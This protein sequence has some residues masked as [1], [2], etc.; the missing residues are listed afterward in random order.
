MR[1]IKE[2]PLF[3][4]IL[5]V[6]GNPKTLILIEPL[7]GI[8]YNLIAPFIT[9]YMYAFGVTDVQIGLMLSI[10]TAVK[11]IIAFLGGNI[12]DKLGRKTTVVLCDFLGWTL[13]CA[14]WAVSRN[15]WMFL[16]ASLINS[17]EQTNIVAWQCLL[18]EDAEEK[19][20]VTIYT[21][22]TIAGL[23]AAFF[24]P[25]S[26]LLIDRHSLV[27]VIRVLYAVFALTMLCKSLIT[28]KFTRET[29]QG[30]LRKAQTKGVPISAMLKE[31]HRIL[32]LLFR[33]ADT[34]R[35]LVVFI[36]LSASGMVTATFFGLYANLNLGIAQSNL[37]LF[38]LMK[39]A[40]M[41]F[42]FFG[43]ARLTERYHIKKLVLLGLA[44]YVLALAWLIFDA[45]GMR[46]AILFTL[47]E[48]AAISLVMPRKDAL[49]VMGID[50]KER[51]RL[52]SVVTAFSLACSSPFGYVA[53]WLSS[54]NRI[55]PFILAAL[56]YTVCAVIMVHYGKTPQPVLTP[57]PVDT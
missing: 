48:S 11:V 36:L 37:T 24:A 49:L 9:L 6:K 21:W 43:L 28:L 32:P 35:I 17:I 34:V 29:K 12:A 15:F 8:P 42:F 18:V 53:G 46:P 2:H 14:L 20:I 23:M 54:I 38:P 47:L 45:G 27:P 55:Y 26:G 56:L 50:K 19:D 4:Y 10:A 39:A 13:A 3:K 5:H 40:V 1:F 16:A 7:W 30:L 41:L 25:L 22:I 51:A 31:Y 44:F 57:G 52:L 33:T